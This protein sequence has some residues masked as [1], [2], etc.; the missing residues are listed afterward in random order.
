MRMGRTCVADLR[1]ED[2]T[3]FKMGN[4]KGSQL[5]E[6]NFKKDWKMYMVLVCELDLA[7]LD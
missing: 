6:V 7:A 3:S 2:E 4:M 1:N 5:L